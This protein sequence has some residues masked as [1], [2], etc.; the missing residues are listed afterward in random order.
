MSTISIIKTEY[1]G[2]SKGEYKVVSV[3]LAEA[4]IRYNS[5]SHR[6][7]KMNPAVTSPG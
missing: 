4:K 7:N 3:E 5:A 1:S 2:S 6:N